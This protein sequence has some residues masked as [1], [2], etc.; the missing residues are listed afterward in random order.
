MTSFQ[1]IVIGS[2][3]AGCCAAFSAAEAGCD[4][5][6]IIDVCP[7]EWV[8]GNGFFTAG[9]FRTV[10]EGLQDL[11]PIVNNVSAEQ[12]GSIDMDPYT[13]EEYLGDIMRLGDGKPDPVLAGA[14]VDASRDTV[15]WLATQVGLPFTLAFH[16]QAYDIGGR[17]KFWGGMAL[18]TD[19]G[20][21]GL[22]AAH[23]RALAKANVDVWFH[24]PALEITMEN[25]AVSGVVV[26]KDGERMH[27]R[28]RAVVLAAGGFEANPHLREKYLGPGWERAIVRGTPYNQGDGLKLAATLGARRS[29]DWA[30]CHST[31]WDA[32]APK[33]GGERKLTNQYTK[34]G[35]PLGIMVNSIG[36]RFVDEGEDY[37]NFTYAKFGKAIQNQPGSYVFQVW[38]SKTTGLLR[39]EE[40]GDGIVKKIFANSIEELAEKLA[41]NGLEAKQKFVETVDEFNRA[42]KNFQAENLNSTWNPAIKDGMS[43]QSSKMQLSVPK[44]NW[45]LTVDQAPFMAVKVACGITFTFGGLAIEPGTA[46]VISEETSKVIPG[47]FCT[48]EMVGLFHG[49]Y[50]GGS[51][52]MAGAVFGRRAGQAAAN[53]LCN[54]N[55]G[56]ASSWTRHS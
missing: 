26:Q 52:L 21:K 20:G 19:E 3:N 39:E 9:A 29:G 27:L 50:P 33:D 15:T 53:P 23:Q 13:R 18:C 12:A 4:K 22:I 46:G 40:Y 37:R 56:F 7:P 10:H 25:G 55:C 8:G 51:G 42:A 32:D 14:V 44:S 36:K 16:R 28:S 11:L 5:V 41:A 35:Y 6:L 24:C 48:G 43:T 54:W 38:D 30:G 45:A 31:C 34:S 17:Q 1:C 49:N 47:L 2:G